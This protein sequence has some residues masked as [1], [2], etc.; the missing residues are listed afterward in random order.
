MSGIVIAL[1]LVFALLFLI[2][3]SVKGSSR[4]ITSVLFTA[5]AF[6]MLVFLVIY[7][8]RRLW[9]VVIAS[10]IFA[11]AYLYIKLP[12]EK[13][14]GWIIL[15]GFVVIFSATMIATHPQT[16][17]LPALIQ[18][19]FKASANI[20]TQTIRSS[21]IFGY[22]PGNFIVSFTK[23]RP[24]QSNKDNY[25]GL[26]AIRFDQSGSFFLTAIA[27]TGLIG[28]FGIAAFFLLFFYSLTARLTREPLSDKSVLLMIAGAG[29]IALG[30]AALLKP[31]NMA[32]GF[33]FWVFIG[34]CGSM[35]Q[36]GAVKETYGRS[37]QFIIFSS[38]ALYI[39]I[40]AGIAVSLFMGKRLLADAEFERAMQIDKSFAVE[41]RLKQAKPDPQTV[42]EFIALLSKAANGDQKNPMYSRT[43]SKALA[44]RLNELISSADAQ[45]PESAASIQ[46][47]TSLMIQAAKLAYDTDSYDIRNI[48]NL[49]EA[50]QAIAPYT[51]G[52]QEQAVAIRAKAIERDPTNPIH[53]LALGRFLL[54]MSVVHSE[55]AKNMK[56]EDRDK[57]TQEIESAAKALSD[58]ESSLQKALGLKDDYPA[59]LYSMSMVRVLQ[60]NNADA[61]N[62]LDKAM[63]ANVNLYPLRSADETLFVSLGSSYQGLGEKEKAETAFKNALFI[64]PNFAA[65]KFQLALLYADQGKKKDALAILKDIRAAEPGNKAINNKI[66]EIETA[67]T[68]IQPKPQK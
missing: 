43:L 38:L 34:M 39:L 9:I 52:A 12:R 51:S 22:G 23:F 49:F 31:S 19:L 5:Y 4:V 66:D 11:L 65:A 35:R 29:V 14:I 13:K 53:H 44:Y 17:A 59:A 36:F 7:N 8:D 57:K 40:S 42:D 28:I 63:I 56:S 60:E 46:N 33:L 45:S 15:P 6:A 64:N 25:L 1:S 62:F 55:R 54:S 48:E 50:Y 58:A 2:R 41:Q 30:T 24:Q 10:L 68:H 67:L 32:L 21:P 61:I 27:A 47:T 3:L 18:P 20:A 37:N 26:W 16:L